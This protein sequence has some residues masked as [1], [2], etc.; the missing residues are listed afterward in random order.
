[1]DS[2]GKFTPLRETPADYYNPVFSP[3][4]KRLALEIND[5]KRRD[6]WVYEWER[7]TLTRLTFNGGDR[8]EDNTKPIWTP[9]GQRITYASFEKS[10]VSDLYWTRADG[11]GDTLRLTETKNK[12]CLPP[13]VP[14]ARSSRSTNSNRAPPG[15]P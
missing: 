2:Q 1:M 5:G 12:K 9:D 3:D 8:V 11:S 10:G 14:T 7:D 13:G 6:I 15:T 4:G